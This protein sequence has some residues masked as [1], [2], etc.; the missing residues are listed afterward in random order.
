MTELGGLR[1]PALMW[2]RRHPRV[3]LLTAVHVAVDCLLAGSVVILF[4]FA[5]IVAVLLVLP[6]AYLG[7]FTAALTDATMIIAVRDSLTEGSM[8]LSTAW[9]VAWKHRRPLAAWAFDLLTVGLAI[10][11][12]AALFGR[13]GRLFGWAAQI[14]WVVIS[15][16]V[17][18]AI[19]IGEVPMP[20]AFDYSRETL[21]ETSRDRLRGVGGLGVVGLVI[22]IPLVGL[23]IAALVVDSS[24]LFVVSWTG[25]IV[26]ILAY[27]FVLDAAMAVLGYAIYAHATRGP[28]PHGFTNSTVRD[29][30]PERT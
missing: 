18:P 20:A 19:V 3:L 11:L 7:A 16:L 17:V 25:L 6:A 13:L 15:L 5:P 23:V 22:T 21:R 30:L 9:A 29:S 28:L 24:L 2:V 27:A 14:A 10:R 1:R 12:V 26:T 8:S 4:F